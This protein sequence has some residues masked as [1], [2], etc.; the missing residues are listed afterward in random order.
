[1]RSTRR[2]GRRGR[3]GIGRSIGLGIGLGFPQAATAA[4]CAA[5]MAVT[6]AC[7]AQQSQPDIAELR[8]TATGYDAESK[9]SA[10]ET[11]L[12]GLLDRLNR[13][14]GLHHAYTRFTDHCT[15]PSKGNF[16]DPPSVDL[17]SCSMGV[18]AVYGVEGDVTDVLRRID[19]AGVTPWQ[20]NLN[21]PGSA[22]G[23]TLDYALEYHRLRGVFPDGLLMPAPSLVSEDRGLV[24]AWDYPPLPD[25]PAASAQVEGE[26][27]PACPPAG[28]VHSRCRIDPQ[29]PDSVPAVRARYGTVLSVRI[30]RPGSTP[31]F[32][33]PRPRAR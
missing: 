15:G 33:V 20:P 16:K 7:A 29:Q 32:T 13:V 31:Y 25:H 22:S 24:I 2:R 19:A 12:R 8:A 6:S 28:P 4:A 21:G 11:R 14:E 5:V 10:E 26:D 27:P 3:R 1:M 17:V 23:G 9:R 18:H 30:G